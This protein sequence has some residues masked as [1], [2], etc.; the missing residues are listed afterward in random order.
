MITSTT[1]SLSN[2]DHIDDELSPEKLAQSV[3]QIELINKAEAELNKA[4]VSIATLVKQPASAETLAMIAA[5]Q[6]QVV[7]AMVGGNPEQAIAMALAQS[8]EKYGKQLSV[9]QGWTNGGL[10][11]FESAMAVMFDGIKTSGETSGYALEDLFQLA[12]MDF[13]SHGY[14]P[15]MDEQMRH[16][17]E[18]T[19]SGSHGYHESWDG[20]AFANNC[21]NVFNYMMNNAPQ[22]S[23][24]HDILIYMNDNCGGVSALQ[25]QYR[26]NFNNTG[27]F[28]CDSGYPSSAGLSPMLRMALMAGYLTTN[29]KVEQSTIEMFLTAPIGTLDVFIQTNTSYASAIDYIFENDGYQNDPAHDGWREVTQNGHQVIDWE[30]RGLGSEYFEHMYNDFP[31]RELTDEDVEEIN[32]IGDQVKM[33]QQTLKYWLSICRDEQMAIA[34]NI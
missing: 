15:A 28:V 21:Q 8:I 17:L 32:R 18:S 4:D 2:L 31:P 5:Q 7:M 10:A 3:A 22:D 9:I 16:F 14:G 23:L 26:N 12:I 25:S 27:G 13:M 24:C 30:G 33:L 20:A 6:K 29:P 34:R 19:G 1:N 11:M